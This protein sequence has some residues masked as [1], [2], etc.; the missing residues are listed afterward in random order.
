MIFDIA[1][2]HF[3]LTARVDFEMQIMVIQAVMTHEQYN[4]EKL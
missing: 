4:R 1:G 3:R 2:N